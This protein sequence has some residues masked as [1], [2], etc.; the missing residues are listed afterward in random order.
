MDRGRELALPS[1]RL[2]RR[3]GFDPSEPL[4][5]PHRASSILPKP[6]GAD[7][8]FVC[9]TKEGGIFYCK[10]DRDARPI[11]AT[12]MVL[13]RL[14]GHVGI[15]TPHCSVIE[16]DDG[17][18]VFG[19]LSP[20]SLA[21]EFEVQAYLT[22]PERDEVGGPR[23]WLGR[24]LSGL[25]AFDLFIGNPD[26]SLGNFLLEN[27]GRRLTAFDFASASLKNWSSE[28]ISIEQ[29]VTLS[30]GRRLRRIHGFDV[31]AACEMVKRL[32]AIPVHTIRTILSDLPGDWISADEGE[33]LCA[34]WGEKTGSRLAV[35][36]AGLGDGSLL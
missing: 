9:T 29:T 19:S 24:Y 17:N 15:A 3:I 21:G 27:P 34:E 31:D 4:L 8:S 22:K 1:S 26:R 20:N 5:I 25:Y 14:A 36:S 12:E 6:N 23:P 11:R 10:E 35:L 28:R 30:V 18:S 13:T 2:P 7:I 32:E 16:C 33:Y